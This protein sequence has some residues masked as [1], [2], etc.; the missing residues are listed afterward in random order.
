MI[1]PKRFERDVLKTID[2]F[3]QIERGQTVI[4]AV[5]GGHDSLCM[6]YV[7]NELKG[8]RG[9]NLCAAHLNHLF[10]EEADCDE[11]FVVDLCK[12]LN[13]QSYTKKVN[14]SQYASSHKISFETA[15]REVR[16]SYFSELERQIPNSV[17]ATAHTAD[18]SAE[19]FIMHL[20]RGSGLT[21]LTGISAKRGMVI[22]PMIETT[23]AEIE[24]YCDIKGLS[25]R[26]DVTNFS[27][28]YARNDIRHNVMPPLKQRGGIKAIARAAELISAEEDF[29]NDYTAKIAESMVNTDGS[30][31]V[32]DAKAF[33]VQPLAVKRRILRTAVSAAGRDIS[34]AHINSI[35]SVAERGC[36]GKLAELPGGITARL[37]AGKIK[38]ETRYTNE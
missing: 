31:V 1:K 22:R 10:R 12:K 27:D 37:E 19:S 24:E 26:I 21:G 14:V 34:L 6:L 5:S 13:L 4:A 16:Y 33:N 28:D 7:L 3:S 8:V 20:L 25:P 9:F 15:G 11:K 30:E 32:I 29:L 38:I 18:D 2:K 36:G 23:R 17:T 35:I